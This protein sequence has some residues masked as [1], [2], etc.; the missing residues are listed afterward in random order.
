MASNQTSAVIAHVLRAVHHGGYGLVDDNVAYRVRGSHFFTENGSEIG[1]FKGNL[2]VRSHGTGFD[3]GDDDGMPIPRKYA[4]KHPLNIG[5]G[6]HGFWLQ[7]GGVDVTDNVAVGHPYSAF[8][9]FVANNRIVT[10]G[11][12]QEPNNPQTKG[13]R[14]ER[15]DV[16]AAE[17]LKDRSLA[18]GNPWLH[19]SAVPFHLA[20]CLGLASRI[21]LRTRG[22]D[23]TEFLVL[24]DQQ[25]LVEDCRFVWNGQ[26]YLLGYSPGL[27]HLRDTQFIGGDPAREPLHHEGIGGG[28]HIPGFLTLENVKIDGY[29]VGCVL[30]ARGAHVIKGGF[31]NGVRKLVVPT[32]WGGKLVVEGVK[33]GHMKGEEPQPILFGADPMGPHLY[34]VPPYT[35]R[36][37]HSSCRDR[38]ADHAATGQEVHRRRAVTAPP[39]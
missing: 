35:N 8:G 26:G 12:P 11:G 34:G 22:I 36:R 6:G 20:R 28:N 30:P 33:F 16:F 7:G 38:R 17:N 23:R 1:R 27:S 32:P 13:T 25:D 10:Y 5:H 18:H 39:Q 31:I 24:H 3:T 2:A 14:W 4:Y 19:T 9:F 37:G 21:G 15:L 29:R